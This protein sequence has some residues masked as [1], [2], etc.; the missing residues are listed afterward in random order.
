M[1][2]IAQV[3]PLA[4]LNRRTKQALKSSAQVRRLADVGFA[5]SAQQESRRC[6]REF[7]KKAGVVVRG[8]CDFAREHSLF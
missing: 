5:I 4:V 3:Q 6:S 8:E 7:L 2:T 1:N